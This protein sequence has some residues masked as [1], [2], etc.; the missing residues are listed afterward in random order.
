VINRW[1]SAGRWASRPTPGQGQPANAWS[2]VEPGSDVEPE[3]PQLLATVLGD[4]VRAPRRHPDPV[5]AE[6]ADQAVQGVPGLVL[7]YVSQ[8]AGRAGQGHVDGE[9]PVLGQGDPVDQA[10]VH[11]VNPELGV[12]HVTQRLQQVLGLRAQG[13]AQLLG[14]LPVGDLPVSQF[15]ALVAH[16]CSVSALRGSP[17]SGSPASA[18]ARA[19]ASF[20]AI[21]PSSAHLMR[22]GYL[23]T[24]SNATASPS[25]S[26]SGSPSPRDCISARNSA[27]TSMASATVLP[28]TMSVSMDVLAW[29]IEQP[30]AS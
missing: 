27:L 12:H 2:D 4:L 5:D 20:H 8:R 26:S 25:T 13:G 15:R 18:S 14:K 7:D 29:L 17:G 6:V 16:V 30:S 28:T 3:R 21:Q 10:E 24:P 9:R 22:A 1:L 23:A 19:V 11:D